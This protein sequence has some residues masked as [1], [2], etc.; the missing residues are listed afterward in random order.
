MIDFAIYYPMLHREIAGSLNR[1]KSCLENNGEYAKELR[2]MPDDT[3]ISFLT[4]AGENQNEEKLEFKPFKPNSSLNSLFSD[5]DII[6][7]VSD[8]AKQARI[9]L[10]KEYKHSFSK[11]KTVVNATNLFGSNRS[12]LP[13]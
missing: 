11:S 13:R 5:E 3:N 7:P 2:F 6:P 1:H 4:T 8:E 9:A 12:R 10:Q